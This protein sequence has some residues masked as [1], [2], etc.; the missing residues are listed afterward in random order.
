MRGETTWT[1]GF[2]RA[3]WRVETVGRTVLTSTPT[4]FH[5]YA[6][7]DAY[8]GAQRVFAHSWRETIPRD[9]V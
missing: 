7:L 5:L 3:D 9:H 6:Q 4:D 2:G 8:E 1:M